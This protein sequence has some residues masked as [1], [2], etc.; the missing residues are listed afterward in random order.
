MAEND[1]VEAERLLSRGAD[2]DDGGEGVGMVPIHLAAM[3]DEPELL[4]LLLRAG[5]ATEVCHTGLDPPDQQTPDRPATHTCEPY[6]HVPLP[7]TAARRGGI[8]AAT[9]LGPLRPPGACAAPPQG[10]PLPT[11]TLALPLTLTLP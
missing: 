11:L 9:H 5:A 8:D 7:W 10:G 4:L 1:A 6:S 2:P 3:G